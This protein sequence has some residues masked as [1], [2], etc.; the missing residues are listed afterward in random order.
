MCVYIWNTLF[1][2][3]NDAYKLCNK[4]FS[5]FYNKHFTLENIFFINVFQTFD[6][7]LIAVTSGGATLGERKTVRLGIMKNDS[8]NGE[9]S[10]VAVDVSITVSILL[11]RSFNV[12]LLNVLMDELPNFSEYMCH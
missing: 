2:F 5:S 11:F 1:F 4:T 6:V 8:P 3:E 10:F 9:F 7:E 12:S